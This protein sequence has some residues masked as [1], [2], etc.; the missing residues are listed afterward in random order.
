MNGKPHTPTIK[1]MFDVWSLPSLIEQLSKLGFSNINIAGPL[2]VIKTKNYDYVVGELKNW[3]YD[4]KIENII[5]S[6][7]LIDFNKTPESFMIRCSGITII[8]QKL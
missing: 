4:E 3:V 6:Y 8:I 1:D 7:P 2:A 5:K